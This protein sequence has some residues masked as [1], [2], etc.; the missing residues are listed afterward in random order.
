MAYSLASARKWCTDAEYALVAASFAGRDVAWTPAALKSKIERTRRLRDKN[1]DRY[2]T[3]RRAN[4]AAGGPKVGK[5]VTA[6][7]VAEKK[8]RLFDETLARLAAKLE[9]LN[10]RRR[11]AELKSAVAAALARKRAGQATPARRK[12]RAGARS[13]TSSATPGTTPSVMLH[14]GKV[15]ASRVRAHNARK[16]AKRDAR[17]R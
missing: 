8:A 10:A 9:K 6:M 2:R 12:P 4:R 5:Q 1:R 3:I 14:K 7:A 11:M 13:G 15:T 17:G 16:Q